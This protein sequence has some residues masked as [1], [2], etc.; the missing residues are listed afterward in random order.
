[1]MGYF[2]TFSP[3]FMCVF[4]NASSYI[5]YLFTITRFYQN[6]C[7][8]SEIIFF[9]KMSVGGSLDNLVNSVYS[10][11]FQRD[12]CHQTAL[13]LSSYDSLNIILTVNS[14]NENICL[15]LCFSCIL[16]QKN[17]LSARNILII[18]DFFI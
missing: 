1:M 11:Y 10:A 6:N 8:I 3:V 7:K 17:F 13:S 5:V 16:R 2:R 14:Y 15:R 18:D 12:F 4:C 9:G